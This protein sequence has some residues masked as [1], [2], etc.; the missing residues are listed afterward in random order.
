MLWLEAEG[1]THKRGWETQT[2]VHRCSHIQLHCLPACHMLYVLLFG[3]STPWTPSLHMLGRPLYTEALLLHDSARQHCCED[4]LWHTWV[5]L[6]TFGLQGSMFCHWP[7][8]TFTLGS[9]QYPLR[10]TNITLPILPYQA[11]L[12]L[13]WCGQSY[14]DIKCFHP[15]I[16]QECGPQHL[17]EPNV[18][19]RKLMLIW[20]TRC[21]NF[22]S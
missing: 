3:Y 6:P 13:K 15:Q 4:C 10:P 14:R 11:C 22:P 16:G 12:E 7:S 2:S 17:G 20:P 21:S 8:P 19:W 18:H 9:S 5:A 1:V